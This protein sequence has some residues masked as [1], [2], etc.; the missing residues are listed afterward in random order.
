MIRPSKHLIKVWVNTLF[1]ELHR[2][3]PIVKMMPEFGFESIFSC[4]VV[5]VFFYIFIF[6]IYILQYS[7]FILL[8]F[9]GW[10]H[11]GQGKLHL[12]RAPWRGRDNSRVQSFKH[13]PYKFVIYTFILFI[14]WNIFC[15]YQFNYSAQKSLINWFLVITNLLP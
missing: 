2:E 1:V 11:I 10:N 12:G 7:I 4:F 9:V 13:S 15:N 3:T 8:F 6:I 5:I 14:S